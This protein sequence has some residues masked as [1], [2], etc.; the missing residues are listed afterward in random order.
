MDIIDVYDE[1]ID[2]F[3]S[4][5]LKAK[6]IIEELLKAS[7]INSH[8]IEC[9]VKGRDQLLEKIERKENKYNE[10]Y[11]ITD[12]LGLRIITYFESEVD[13]IS[14]IIE[15]EFK[16]DIDNTIDKRQVDSDR[17]GY[18]SI[19]YVV[20]LPAKRVRL[21]ENKV[22]KSIRFEIQLRTILQHSWAEI[23]HDLGYKSEF[24]IPAV[25]KR[26]FY[27]I[28]AILETADIEFSNLKSVLCKYESKVKSSSTKDLKNVQIDKATLLKY[29]ETSKIVK[30][31][32]AALVNKLFRGLSQNIKS[33]RHISQHILESI[34]KYQIKSFTE[35]DAL[36]NKHKKK[37]I[38]EKS[39]KKV[40]TGTVGKGD[41]IRGASLSMLFRY[42][43]TL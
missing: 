15:K 19:H 7:S 34:D 16:V 37:I 24:E 43:E 6:S 38:K 30:E 29:I 14:K 2:V 9:R 27:R 13:A 39:K 21:T 8:Q 28:A 26:S 18:R 23:E 41:M 35:L 36:L 10:L 25:A 17:F 20:E 4:L 1:K 31:V 32:D 40:I 42:I 12:V 3:E 22:F 33:T 11:D 5:G